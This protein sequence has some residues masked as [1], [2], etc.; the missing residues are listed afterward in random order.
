MTIGETLMR[1]LTLASVD[2]AEA[3]QRYADVVIEPEDVGV[4]FLE[5]HQIDRLREAGRRAARD[6]LAAAP[7]HIFG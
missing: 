3:A 7:A 1:T 6:A 5:F 4:G 2:T